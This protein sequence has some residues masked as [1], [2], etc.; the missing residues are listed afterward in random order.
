MHV[1]D[2]LA[3]VSSNQPLPMPCLA[4]PRQLCFGLGHRFVVTASPSPL[5]FSEIIIE[6]PDLS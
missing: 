4:S 5:H 2:K 6:P 3:S 1:F